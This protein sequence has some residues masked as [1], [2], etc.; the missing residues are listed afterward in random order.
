MKLGARGERIRFAQHD[1]RGGRQV[2]EQGCE[3]QRRRGICCR[4]HRRFS[5]QPFEHPEFAGG[6][7][8]DGRHFFARHLRLGIEVAQGLEFIAEELKPDRPRAG[9]WE[10]IENA[11]A[12]RDLAF[13]CD[14][15]LRF[16]G[17]LF[18]PFD[19]VQRVKPVAALKPAGALAQLHGREGALD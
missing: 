2:I 17:L 1:Q 18:E 19:Q 7:Q 9:Q 6:R 16:V 14:L 3:L 15:R 8:R 10:D 12:L 5:D 11:A 13:L 4:R